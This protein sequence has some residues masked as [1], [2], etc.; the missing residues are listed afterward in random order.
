MGNNE[1]EKRKIIQ[2]NNETKIQ[3]FEKYQQN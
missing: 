3:L 1:I 2:E